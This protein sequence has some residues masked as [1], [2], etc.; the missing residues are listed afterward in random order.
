MQSGLLTGAFDRD[1][2]ESLAK[3]D[4]RRGTPTF[5]E[6]KFSQ[7]LALVDGLRKVAEDVECS[8][9][10]LAIAWT[11]AIDGVTAA[12]VG[13]RQADQVDGWIGASDLE[14]SS[15]V[16]EAIE[17]IIRETGAGTNE[18]PTQVARR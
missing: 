12:I 11:L 16:V 6:P 15:D 5:Q 10:E 1:R 14:L 8:L 4:W 7:N 9:A 3:D 18:P 17:V 2:V 13:A